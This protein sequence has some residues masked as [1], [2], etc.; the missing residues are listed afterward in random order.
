MHIDIGKLVR[1]Y[2]ILEKHV[3]EIKRGYI[4]W[5]HRV[6]YMVMFQSLFIE[7]YIPL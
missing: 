7:H 6:I 2:R 4:P 3:Q 5:F 1:I